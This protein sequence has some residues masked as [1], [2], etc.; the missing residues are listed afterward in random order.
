M[1]ESESADELRLVPGDVPHVIAGGKRRDLATQPM[2]AHLIFQAASELLSQEEIDELP[3]NRPRIVRHDHGDTSYL[4]EV[5]RA[6]NGICL[7]IRPSRG[8]ASRPPGAGAKPPTVAARAISITTSAGSIRRIDAL[9]AHMQQ[10]KASDLHLSANN[11]PAMRVDGEIHFLKQYPALASSDIAAMVDEIMTPKAA[12]DFEELHDAAFA[13]ELAGK[14]RFRINVFQDQ[15]GV[16]AVLRHIPID[17]L[18][19]EELGLPK[20]C[21]DLCA[22][23]KGLVVVTGPTGSGKSTTLAAMIHHINKTRSDHIL[24]IEDPIE[25]VHKNNLCLVNQREVGRHTKSFKSAL[26]AA[27][28]EDPN[29]V[30]VGEMD[31]CDTL[32]MAIETAEKGPLV[33]GTLHITSAV[34]TVQRI[35]DQFPKDRQALVRVMLSESLKGIIAQALCKKIGGGRTVAHEILLGTSA[36]ASLIRDGRT[37]EMPSVMQA[38]KAQGMLTMN[39]SLLSLVQRGEIEPKEAWLNAIDKSELLSMFQAS[40]IATTF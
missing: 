32:A 17:I 21:L 33:F 39:E 40:N 37:L 7:A 36:I 34:G 26:H 1:F 9:L 25:F 18:S 2:S 12:A 24:T 13:Y 30:L 5:G 31:D 28:R 14:G 20:A 22:L 8:P 11:S 4:V 23:P 19:A 27:L 6:A 10:I 16:G 38:S 35:V 29:I 15:N 3:R